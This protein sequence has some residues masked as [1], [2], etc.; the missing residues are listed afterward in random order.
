MKIIQKLLQEHKLSAEET[1]FQ[2]NELTLLDINK[3][4]DK[5]KKDLLDSIRE[6]ELELSMRR[7]FCSELEDLL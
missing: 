6:L 3:F 1:S 4:S 7:L 5:E 2:L